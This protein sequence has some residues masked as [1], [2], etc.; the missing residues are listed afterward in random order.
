QTLEQVYRDQLNRSAQSAAPPPPPPPAEPSAPMLRPPTGALT[1]TARGLP[2]S[3][4][5]APRF[6]TAPSASSDLGPG[7]DPVVV[8][9]FGAQPARL[10]T[11]DRQELQRIASAALRDGS[12]LKVIGHSGTA[13]D[14]DSAQ[15]L[16]LSLDRAAA[17]AAE[18][19]RLGVP[20][21]RVTA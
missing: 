17:V 10:P 4:E 14:G 9:Q 11:G 12:R 1:H 8:I 3:A 5:P 6:A 19:S 13:G 20:A 15:G 21:D 16:R 2:P 18:L 7:G